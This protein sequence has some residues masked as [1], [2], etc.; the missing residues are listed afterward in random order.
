[1]EREDLADLTIF[2]AVAEARSFTAAAKKLGLSQSALSHV[3]RRLEARLGMRLLART[4][5][6]VTPT[7]TG[8]RLLET[9]VPALA[10]IDER[11]S[12]LTH[13]REKPA[14]T[15]R[16]SSSEYVAST[17]LWPA[18]S[19]I[20]SQY[21]EINIELEVNN[22][23]I[24]IVK[25]RFDAGVRIGGPVPKD[26]VA[27]PI[28]PKLRMAAFASP[29][30]IK[31]HG[32]PQSPAELA[33]H[34]CINLRLTPDASRYAWE[35]STGSREF[36]VKTDG[37]LVFNRANLVIEAAIAGHGIGYLLEC[38]VQSFLDEGTLVQVLDGWCPAFDGYQLY[39]P[40]RR[41]NS[42][43]FRILIDTLRY[44]E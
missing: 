21:P 19:R 10:N 5:R 9:L 28:S 29:L 18:I 42:Q 17:I 35:F 26:M 13:F 33:H 14:G 11:I 31:K 20:V 16:I 40:V 43:A 38:A 44:R 4:T 27:I 39:F 7:E 6:S 23:F 8:S 1:M 37:Q 30:Y 2:I 12:D 36:K 15:I 32:I 3:I 25:E 41:Q 34:Q 24:D 22:A